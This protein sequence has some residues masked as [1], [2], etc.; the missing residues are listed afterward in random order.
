[1]PKYQASKP[2]KMAVFSWNPTPAYAAGSLSVEWK[3]IKLEARCYSNTASKPAYVE[4]AKVHPSDKGTELNVPSCVEGKYSNVDVRL[5]Q[6]N[7]DA[8]LVGIDTVTVG[9]KQ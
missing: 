1:M 3:N 4:I 9:F 5:T 7:N 2:I 8:S 6:L